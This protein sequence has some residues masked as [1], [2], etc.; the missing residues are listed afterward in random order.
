MGLFSPDHVN[1]QFNDVP[2]VSEIKRVA[3]EVLRH[4][5]AANAQADKM[6]KA[7]EDVVQVTHTTN[8][9]IGTV[10]AAV[11]S[12]GAKVGEALD[13]IAAAILH[14]ANTESRS[15]DM[16]LEV[17]RELAP[18][19]DEPIYRQTPPGERPTFKGVPVDYNV[20][21][22]EP[23]APAE[24]RTV[25]DAIA[26]LYEIGKPELADAIKGH[27]AQKTA[28]IALQAETLARLECEAAV[29]SSVIRDLRKQVAEMNDAS[30]FRGEQL[31]KSTGGRCGK[32]GRARRAA[33][34]AGFA[35]ADSDVPKTRAKKS[36][37]HS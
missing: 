10:A 6:R 26:F 9:Q 1:V 25:H 12:R 16:L 37:R 2:L 30:K 14:G 34:K 5:N 15:G 17:L 29:Q 19:A 27:S 24:K 18:G 8:E 13:A 31:D 3:D 35:V 20:G 7:L 32:K 22:D 28:M 23:K 21:M 33:E 36:R 11:M 4:T